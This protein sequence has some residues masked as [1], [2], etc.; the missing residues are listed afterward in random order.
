MLLVACADRGTE[1]VTPSTVAETKPSTTTPTVAPAPTVP[2]SSAALERYC[3]HALETQ[4]L[5][6]AIDK[7][8]MYE[9][10]R[11]ANRRVFE[12]EALFSAD[13]DELR[14]EGRA[15]EATNV[16]DHSTAL[17]QYFNSWLGR[18]PN[19]GRDIL[20]DYYGASAQARSMCH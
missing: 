14:R 16:A 10:E 13:A 11:S 12:L 17:R 6:N 5:V 8:Q 3:R 19:P 4:A 1:R 9:Q 18:G 20:Q 2:P 7:G 15:V